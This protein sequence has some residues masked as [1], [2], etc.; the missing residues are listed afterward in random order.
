MNAK[1]VAPTELRL[2]LNWSPGSYKHCAPKRAKSFLTSRLTLIMR[3]KS[4][5][6]VTAP[7]S[8]LYWR[9]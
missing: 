7:D 6:S 2:R 8:Y 1:H 5:K 3:K 4:A 9:I